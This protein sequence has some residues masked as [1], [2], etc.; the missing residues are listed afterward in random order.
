MIGSLKVSRNVFSVLLKVLEY[1]GDAIAQKSENRYAV[2]T[3]WTALETLFIDG[4]VT[5]SKGDIV[6]DAL[7]EIIQ[8]TYIIKRLKYLQIDFLRN[9]RAYNG[10]L[11][12]KGAL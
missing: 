6:K 1:H 3:L 5:G 11:I 10:D 7:I 4:Q 9:I 2:S 8:R 12:K